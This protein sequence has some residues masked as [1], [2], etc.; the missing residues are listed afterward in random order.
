MGKKEFS[1]SWPSSCLDLFSAYGVRKIEKIKYKKI[2]IIEITRNKFTTCI[3]LTPETHSKSNSLLFT[4]LK[5]KKIIEKRKVKG[6]NFGIR[7]KR[8]RKEN[9]K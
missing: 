6:I 2:I 5:I 3:F 1:L 7:P 9:L 8:F 4:C